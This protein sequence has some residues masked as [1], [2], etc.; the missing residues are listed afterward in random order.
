MYLTEGAARIISLLDKT[1]FSR[2]DEVMSLARK[3]ADAVTS[4]ILSHKDRPF[5]GKVE[6]TGLALL[7]WKLGADASNS[8]QPTGLYTPIEI[9]NPRGEKVEP[10]DHEYLRAV[11]KVWNTTLLRRPLAID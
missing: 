1:L 4:A 9:T 7:G 2:K 3:F 11:R 10:M 6:K 8:G 5:P